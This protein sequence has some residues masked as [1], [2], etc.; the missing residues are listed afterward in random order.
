MLTLTVVSDV[1]G[2]LLLAAD[3]GEHEDGEE[4]EPHARRVPQRV[5]KHCRSL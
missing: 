3:G 1:A 5:H 2:G 4:N